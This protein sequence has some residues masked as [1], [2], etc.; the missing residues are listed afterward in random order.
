MAF[1][2]VCQN[3]DGMS[4]TDVLN[5]SYSSVEEKLF[6]DSYFYHFMAQPYQK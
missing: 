4:S 1:R 2:V 6:C 5:I 3:M